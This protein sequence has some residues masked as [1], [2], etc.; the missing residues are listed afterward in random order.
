MS[1]R[2]A[3]KDWG[4]EKYTSLSKSKTLSKKSKS[5][6]NHFSQL[7]HFEG[8]F[9]DMERYTLYQAE[10]GTNSFACFCGYNHLDYGL[11]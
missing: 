6:G 3:V 7:T 10:D 8:K 2:L 4:T 1:S 5:G 11:I 9:L